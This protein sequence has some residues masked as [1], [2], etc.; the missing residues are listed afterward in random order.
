MRVWLKSDWFCTCAPFLGLCGADRADR[1]SVGREDLPGLVR[2][3]MKLRLKRPASVPAVGDVVGS[4]RIEPIPG[5]GFEVEAEATRVLHDSAA[6]IPQ[7]LPLEEA[8][9]WT[10]SMADES[11]D[12][13]RAPRTACAS[14]VFSLPR[15]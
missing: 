15:G 11:G 10:Q 7:E 13:G 12:H 4:A 3:R 8:R 9:R 5:A 14:A 2:L 6:V 1:G